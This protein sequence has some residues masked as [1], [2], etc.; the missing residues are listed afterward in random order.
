MSL[1]FGGRGSQLLT[2]LTSN[3]EMIKFAMIKAFRAGLGQ[4]VAATAEK[5]YI[6]GSLFEPSGDSLPL[7]QEVAKGLLLPPIGRTAGANG[8]DADATAPIADAKR[9]IVGEELC[10]L[11]GN[12]NPLNFFD[13]VTAE[14]M[15]QL[16]LPDHLD[17]MFFTVFTNGALK[18]NWT[19]LN[20]DEVNLQKLLPDRG[21]VQEVM[22]RA[23]GPNGVLQPVFICELAAA[24]QQYVRN[25][26][27]RAATAG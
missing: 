1:F 4:D 20:L 11:P 10:V 16:I 5:V 26:T 21:H 18:Q 17:A 23:A 13:V 15:Q 9:V 7:K 2:W 25:A 24:M 6:G 14:Q 19:N 22:R 12:P 27:G 3:M 8:S